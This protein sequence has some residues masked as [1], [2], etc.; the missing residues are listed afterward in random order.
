MVKSE[1][2]VAKLKQLVEAEEA[3]LNR[4]FKT[5]EAT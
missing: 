2:L 1:T 4:L 5:K 3:E